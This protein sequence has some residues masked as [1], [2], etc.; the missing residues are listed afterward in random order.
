MEERIKNTLY[1]LIRKSDF[2][3]VEFD[4]T[5]FALFLKCEWCDGDVIII[6]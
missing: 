3:K 4:F 2:L 6:N 1:T 5:K